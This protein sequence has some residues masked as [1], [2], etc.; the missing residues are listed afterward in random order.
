[1]LGGVR[2]KVDVGVSIG[3]QSSEKELINKV[4]GYLEE[5]YKRIKIK[6]APGNDIQF[7]AALRKEFPELL[8]PGGCKLSIYSR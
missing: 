7:V 3:I 8:S 2:N 4:E 5:G 6:I 1:M